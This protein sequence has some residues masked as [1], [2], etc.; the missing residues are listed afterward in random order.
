MRAMIFQSP[1]PEV[2]IPDAPLTPFVFERA[3]EYGDK[4]AL[5]CAATGETLTYAR[6]GESVRRA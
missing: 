3:E 4:P 2:S 6:L 1:H 5:I